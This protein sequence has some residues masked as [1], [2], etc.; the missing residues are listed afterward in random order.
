MTDGSASIAD[1]ADL[2]LMRRVQAGD[3]EAF[4]AL[5]DRFAARAY[6]L[7]CAICRDESRAE[8]DVQEAFLS[9]WLGRTVYD[10]AR[11]VVAAWVV[12]GVKKSRGRLAS[13]PR[14]PPG[15]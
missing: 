3:A 6:R 2:A 7:A 10:P 8:D 5:Y 11:G 13:P 9:L 1:G 12:S 15:R 4:G 14:P